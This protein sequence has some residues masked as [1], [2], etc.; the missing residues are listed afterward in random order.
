[1][2][3]SIHRTGSIA[4]ALLFALPAGAQTQKTGQ[5]Q[6]VG[7]VLDS[8]N[9]GFLRNASI[10][11]E[12]AR[13]STESDSIGRFKFDSVPPGTYQLG[14]FHPVL[15]ALDVSIA[16]R[17]FQTAADSATVVILSVPSPATIVKSRCPDKRA[18]EGSSAILG[19]VADPETLQ[20][21]PGAEVS[22]AWTEIEISRS[23]GMRNTPHVV[24]DT[25]DSNGAYRLC[26][27]PSSLEANLKAR[28]GAAVT[29]EIPVSLGNRPVEVQGRSLL[30]SKEDST[31]RTGSAAVVGV[32]QLE[33]D[34]ANA[35]SRVELEGTDVAVM[36]NEKGEFSMRNLPSG[37]HNILA[38]HLGYVVQS[39]TVD[40][41]SREPQRVALKLPRYVAV[42]D[43][44]LVTARRNAALDKTGFNMRKKSAAGYFL[45]AD[46]IA[47]MHAF[48]VADI[49]RMVPGLR[50]VSGPRGE[51][52]V[53]SPRDLHS[54][55]DYWVDD[56]PFHEI[57]PGDVNNFINGGEIVAVEVYQSGLAPPQYTRGGMGCTTI[58]LWTRFRVRS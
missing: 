19:H 53:T 28:R 21:V 16:T 25:T 24:Y 29:S 7:V 37:T 6:I 36:T 22:V 8:V 48:Y 30:L 5:A 12:P 23:V 58:V 51:P 50:V 18:A 34:P 57:E 14:V 42:M 9:G 44:V 11:L 33:G 17:Q 47:K 39:A 10:L 31:T 40:L 56:V 55:V 43:P 27:L 45:D 35:V 49:L 15:D 41:N 52:I 4:L 54:C 26:G 46:R 38:R 3:E 13:R 20:P 1:M 2:R 32:V